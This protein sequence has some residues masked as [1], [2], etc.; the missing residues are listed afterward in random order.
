VVAARRPAYEDLLGG[1]EAGWLFDPGDAGSLA[2]TLER[3][4]SSDPE[5]LEAKRRAVRQRVERLGWDE[6]G[7]RTAALIREAAS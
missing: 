1:E 4:A 3:A 7:A 5:T 6:I 2:W